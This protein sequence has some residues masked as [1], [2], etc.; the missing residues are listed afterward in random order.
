L[1]VLP[2][3]PEAVGAQVLALAVAPRTVLTPLA[4]LPEPVLS[5]TPEA[6]VAAAFEVELDGSLEPPEQPMGQSSPRVSGKLSGVLIRVSKLNWIARAFNATRDG[7]R[8]QLGQHH[9]TIR[10]G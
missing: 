8:F 5:P 7:N 2:A 10:F 6:P 9:L 1:A 4:V 3:R